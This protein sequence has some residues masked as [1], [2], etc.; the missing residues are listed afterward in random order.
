[1]FDGSI[2]YPSTAIADDALDV[3]SLDFSGDSD[4]ITSFIVKVVVYILF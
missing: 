4:S 3:V 2:F 1:M